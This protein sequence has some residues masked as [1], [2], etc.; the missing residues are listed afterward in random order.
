MKRALKIVGIQYV[1]YLIA[2]TLVV[3][4]LLNG[5]GV[6]NVG[7]AIAIVGLFLLFVWRVIH[8]FRAEWPPTEADIRAAT[9]DFAAGPSG[10]A[11]INQTLD[12]NPSVKDKHVGELANRLNSGIPQTS[13]GRQAVWSELD[14]HPEEVFDRLFGL[15][16]EHD[17]PRVL[18]SIERL[19]REAS[20]A[21]TA[22]TDELFTELRAKSEYS[23]YAALTL[24]RVS[25][26]ADSD[27]GD[28]CASGVIDLLDADIPG[29]WIAVTALGRLAADNSAADSKIDELCHADDQY[30]REVASDIKA[31]YE[32]SDRPYPAG[33]TIAKFDRSR[34]PARQEPTVTQVPQSTDSSIDVPFQ[35]ERE[36]RDNFFER[37]SGADTFGEWLT[38]SSD[39]TEWYEEGPMEWEE[40]DPHSDE[41]EWGADEDDDGWDW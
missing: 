39:D 24:A 36:E 16:T 8:K 3:D 6:G 20:E 12:G 13:K 25:R 31:H 17:E 7:K 35:D 40:P 10:A 30:L 22:Y 11:E 26:Y 9:D 14:C 34:Q 27:I 2:A 37:A 29:R 33:G 41:F 5:I 15:Y 1:V 19:S 4:V 21:A 32:D 23:P 28:R 38:D 18:K